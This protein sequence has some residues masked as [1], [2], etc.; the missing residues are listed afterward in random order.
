MT[1]RDILSSL[2]L[3]F[4]QMFPEL[5]A[6]SWYDGN[7]HVLYKDGA[8][9]PSSPIIIII[10]I[11]IIALQNAQRGKE[12]EMGLAVISSDEACAD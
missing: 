9:E 1:S 2:Q 6:G 7:V 11:I 3:F 12:I 8:F 10:I 5:I 4:R